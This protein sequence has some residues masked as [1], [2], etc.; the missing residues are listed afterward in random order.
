[1]V[2]DD[3]ID[4]RGAIRKRGESSTE[5]RLEEN[6]ADIQDRDSGLVAEGR[7]FGALASLDQSKPMLCVDPRDNEV[8]MPFIKCSG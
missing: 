6:R 4:H 8:G 5:V 7:E 2:R 3:A 1:M